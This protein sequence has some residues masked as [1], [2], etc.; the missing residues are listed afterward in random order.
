MPC[1]TSSPR[2]YFADQPTHLPPVYDPRAVAQAILHAAVTP[3]RDIAVGSGSR[4]LSLASALAPWAV[5]RFMVRVLL[6][7]LHSGEPRRGRPTLDRPGEDL[8]ERGTYRG[9]TR[10][11]LYTALVTRPALSR[12]LATAAVLL[13]AASLAATGQTTSVAGSGRPKTRRSTVRAA[14]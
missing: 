7:R 11:S 5:D 2:N 9:L 12:L 1:G 6:P 4:A 14:Q 8:R 3:T 13:V 10:P